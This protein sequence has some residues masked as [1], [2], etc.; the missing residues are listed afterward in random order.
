[1]RLA[2]A[3]CVAFCLPVAPILAQQDA[4]DQGTAVLVLNQERLLQ[5]T[6]YGMRLQRELEAASAALA[7]ENRQIESLL[8]EEEL[9]LTERRETM[10]PDE[11]RGL[12]DEFDIRVTAIRAAQDAKTRDLQAQ[13]DAAQQRFFEESVPVLLQLIEDRGAAVLLDSRSVLL[14]ADSIDITEE[15]IAEIDETLGDGGPDP[16]IDL[17]GLTD[18]E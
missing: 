3:L 18:P 1:M 13:A 8:T 10:P 5:L 7:N 16:I 2:L 11:F 17:P 12:A 14:S 9:A 15:A 4:P 6:Q